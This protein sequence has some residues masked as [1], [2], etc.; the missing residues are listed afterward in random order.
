MSPPPPDVPSRA[1]PAHASCSACGA[2]LADDQRYCLECGER[3]HAL[4]AAVAALLGPEAATTDADADEDDAAPARGTLVSPRAAALAVLAT[5]AFGSVLGTVISPTSSSEASSPLLVAVT[6]A[7]APAPA[8][9]APAPVVEP[10]AAPSGAADVPD[11]SSD[12]AATPTSDTT[13]GDDTS[14]T[15][16]GTAPADDTPPKIKHVFL[17]MLNGHGYDEAFGTGSKAPY[18]SGT[19]AKQGEVVQNYYAATQGELANGIALISGQGPTAQTQLNCP[20]FTDV[21]STGT[22][23]DDQ[24]LG[25]GCV[26]PA[27]TKTL[28]D[29]LQADGKTWKAYVEDIG[30][31]PVGDPMTCRHPAVGT[32][33]ALQAPRPGDAYVTWRN[34]FVYF[35]SVIDG[36]ACGNSDI[37][38]GQLNLDLT[39]ADTTPAVSYIVPNRCHDGSVTP[40]ADG[41]PAGLAAADAWLKTIVPQIMGSKGYADGGLIAIT[42]D[43]APQTGDGA[44][45]TACCTPSAFPNLAAAA[46]GATTAAPA[47]TAIPA[48]TS[49]PASPALPATTAS[50][51]T[52]SAPATT[53]SPAS[54]TAP[55]GTLPPADDGTSSPGGG[56]VGLLLLSSA[57]KAG[58]VDRTDSYNHFSLLRSIEDLFGLDHLGYAGDAAMPSFDK[59]VYNAKAKATS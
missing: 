50:P 13:G 53:T 30:N 2:A 38:L 24:V 40:C 45:A 58:S 55:A 17:I 47:S 42:F 5:L 57:V 22:G 41:Q 12:A 43:Q 28:G 27:A 9:V 26:Y 19:L 34:P 18:L 39:S 49:V 23:D 44:D 8:P 54:T 56:R 37:G 20:Q 51:A 52:T 14:S 25:D 7:R 31:G 48:T 1:R 15:D 29:Q 32:A 59:A 4:P 16:T 10:P 35:H 6:P 36:S 21:A 3:V 11:S 46:G 33:D